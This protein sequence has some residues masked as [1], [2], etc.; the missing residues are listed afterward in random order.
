MRERLT[1]RWYWVLSALVA[2]MP[3]CFAI[4]YQIKSLPIAILWLTGLALLCTRADRRRCYGLAKAVMLVC[5]L[6]VVYAALNI[7]GHHSGWAA[8]DMPVQELLFL[9][10]AAVFTLPLRWRVVWVGFSLV[11]CFLG[12][13][14]IIERYVYGIERP[15]GTNNGDW[16]AIEFAMFLV[17]LALL[18]LIQLLRTQTT[19]WEK[20]VHA[21][22]AVLALYGA[23]LSLSRGPLLAFI[24]VF[25]LVVLLHARRTGRWR[26]GLAVLGVALAGVVL[27]VTWVQPQLMQRLAEAH[28]EA[29]T[30]SHA[31]DAEGSVRE[32]LELWRTARQA[33][34]EHPWS[35]VGLG[36][37]GVFARAQVAHGRSD[38]SIAQYQHAHSEYL[39]AAATGG[40][41]GLLVMLLI[42]LVP[43]AYFLKHTNDPDETAATTAMLGLASVGIYALCALTD[44]VFY[45]AMP[46]S[47]YFFLATGLA[48][49]VAQQRSAAQAPTATRA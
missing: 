21:L 3:L 33:F 32:R 22:A 16:G 29:D 34:E 12:S 24:P 14:N 7:L 13:I 2:V 9:G 39:D 38:T 8:F 23:L 47:L 49:L 40:I 35:G 44:N 26:Q 42:F 10:I 17:V 28:V 20:A 27:A 31:H 5:L 48:V 43:L 45:R 37:F 4:S 36:Q 11:A 30:Y 18:A 25:L 46:H 6:N 15:Y 41:P 19:R 1:L